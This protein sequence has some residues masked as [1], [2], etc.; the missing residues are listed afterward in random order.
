MGMH[1]SD[2]RMENGPVPPVL[3]KH[4]LFQFCWPKAVA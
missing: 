2:P 4:L 3:T 1:R